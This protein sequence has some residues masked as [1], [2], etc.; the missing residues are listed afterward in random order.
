MLISMLPFFSTAQSVEKGIIIRRGT[1]IFTVVSPDT[2]WIAADSKV[3]EVNGNN[4]PT[5]NSSNRNKIFETNSILYGFAAI[6]S[7][8]DKFGKELF[9]SQKIMDSIIKEKKSIQSSFSGYKDAILIKL[10]ELLD[11]LLFKEYYTFIE[12]YTHEPIHTFFMAS[13]ENEGPKYYSQSYTIVKNGNKYKIREEQANIYDYGTMIFMIGRKETIKKFLQSHPNYFSNF[14]SMREKLT[15]LIS[16]EAKENPIDVGM[17][18][19]IV[20][21]YKNDFKWF[22]DNKECIMTNIVER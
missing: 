11:T 13:F 4:S 20:E 19:N 12:K 7:G 17:P 22:R 21:I 1:T 3:A 16:L 15:C 9:D 18:V 10:N 14:T 2:I 6:L 8:N 5:G